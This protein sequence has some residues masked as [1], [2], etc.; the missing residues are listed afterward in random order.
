MKVG[1]KNNGTVT[2]ILATTIMDTGAYLSS[3]PGVVRRAGQGALYLYRCPNVRYDGYLTYTNRPSGGSYRALGAPQGHFALELTA[4]RIAQ[5]LG[6]DPLDF[7][8]KNHMGPEGQ[9]GER[10]TP[11]GEV[12]DTQPVEGGVPFS[13]NGLRQCLLQGAEA[14]EWRD[15]QD[16]FSTPSGS[17]RTGVGMSMFI[18]RGGPGG[19]SSAR[20]RLNP[21][22]T[23]HLEAGIMD[24]GEGATT[25]LV[26]IAAEELGLPPDHIH[27]T[28]ADTAL[29]PEAP[30]TA[31]STVTVS[32]GLAV[33][34]TA[35]SLRERILEA[36]AAQLETEV[37]Q[38][39]I[40]DGV[41]Y[42]VDPIIRTAVRLK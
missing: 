35:A 39:E 30:I 18:Y 33:K 25:V 6:M 32:T 22:D 4:D 36:A 8:L 10:V 19:K 28:L 1:V 16:A 21:D 17:I 13:S 14:I 31:G 40:R 38:L 7:R 2:A 20:V 27:T 23:V 29:T 3:G 11:Q 9:P 37:A 24:V 5:E 12:V 41:V 42:Q 34:D 26:Q 15:R